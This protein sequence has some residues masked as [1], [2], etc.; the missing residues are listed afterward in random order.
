MG[1]TPSSPEKSQD[2]NPGKCHICGKEGHWNKGCWQRG[3]W[4]SRP[5]RNK[6]EETP[7]TGSKMDL[8]EQFKELTTQQQWE[9]RRDK[10][11]VTMRTGDLDIECLLDIGAELTCLPR[12]YEIKLLLDRTVRTAYGAGA[13]RVEIKRTKPMHVAFDPYELVNFVWL[14]MTLADYGNSVDSYRLQVIDD[15][16]LEDAVEGV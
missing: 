12:K 16:G 4:Q 6:K 7:K 2:K 1:Q 11:Y 3:K 8:L 15:V 9:Q 10:L 5:I 13:D 14:P